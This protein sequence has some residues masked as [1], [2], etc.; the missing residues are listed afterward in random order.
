[1]YIEDH[2]RKLWI[3]LSFS[4]RLK[5]FLINAWVASVQTGMAGIG[6]LQFC[7]VNSFRTKFILGFS[8]FMGISVPH[9]FNEYTSV[10]GFGS[11]HCTHA[12]KMSKIQ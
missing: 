6:F 12:R 7:N 5:T 9:Y 10:A 2:H 11:V 1:M 3:D 8:L 4:F